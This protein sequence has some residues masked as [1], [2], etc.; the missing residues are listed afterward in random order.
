MFALR[1]TPINLDD[2]V[3]LRY[4]HQDTLT[5]AALHPGLRKPVMDVHEYE[6]LLNIQDDIG[7]KAVQTYLEMELDR[8]SK[9]ANK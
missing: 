8:V 1:Q 5:G 3:K 7:K 4:F 9:E 2:I 6:Q